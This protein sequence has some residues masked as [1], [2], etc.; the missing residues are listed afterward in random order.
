MKFSNFHTHTRYCDGRDT[1]AEMVQAAW[2]FKC[3][4]LGFSEHCMTDP[5]L[6][7]MK[8]DASRAY[9]REIDDLRKEYEGRVEVILG[10][11]QDIDQGLPEEGYRYVIGSVHYLIPGE[12]AYPIDHSAEY[13]LKAVKEAYGGDFYAYVEAYYKRIV[14]VCEETGCDI[15]GH[16]DLI[17]KFNQDN[18]L[19]DTSHPRARRAAE[20]ALETLLEKDAVFELNT[21]AVARG[22]RKEGYL[23]DWMLECIREKGKPVLLTTDC[24]DRRNLLCR[25]EEEYARCKRLGVEV[26]E[27][28]NYRP[29]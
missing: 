7:G 11:E 9:R 6:F 16:F 2:A 22:Y 18:A 12:E 25:I 14:T 28:P 8:K 23:E 20:E 21:G 3:P 15:I 29:L 1:P 4:A 27:R 24:H 17:S 13:Q 10:I 19:Y 5:P 26:I